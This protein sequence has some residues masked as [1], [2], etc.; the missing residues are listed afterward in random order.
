MRTAKKLVFVGLSLSS[1]WGNGHATTYR[2]LLKGLAADGHEL[3]F[4]ERDVEWYAANRDLPSPGF[5][6]LTLYASLSE[7]RGLL[8]EHANADAIIIGSYVPDGVEVIDLAA[9]MTPRALAFYDIDTPVTLGKLARGDEEFL[10]RR[11][12]PL[13]DLYF[14]FAGGRALKKLESEYGAKK[15]VPLYCSVDPDQ[16]GPTGESICWDLGY[17][18]TYSPDRQPA[19]ERLLVEPARRLPDLSFVVAGPQ[20]P[21]DIDWPENVERIDHLPPLRHPSFYS[22]QRFTLNVTRA[23]MIAL[24]HSPSVRLFEAAACGAPI[25]SD[26]WD[27]LTDLLPDGQAILIA[28]TTEQVI[29][30][31]QR[32]SAA[33]SQDIADTARRIVLATHTGSARARELVEAIDSVLQSRMIGCA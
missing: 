23:D 25:I 19:I 32:T 20:Y 31:L 29:D 18:G 30:I 7:L 27:G 22:R 26:R 14:S 11:Q 17:L 8:A 12:I 2:A 9:S 13:F 10:A 1:S 33:R 5:C 21:A 4:L 16:Y 24:G 3:V 28:D 6:K 15:A